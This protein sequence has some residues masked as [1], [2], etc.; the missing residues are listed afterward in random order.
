MISCQT[1]LAG[2]PGRGLVMLCRNGES[3]VMTSYGVSCGGG[4]PM[5][6]GAC[7][8]R[9]ARRSARHPLPFDRV[10]LRLLQAGGV[11]H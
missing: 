2:Q 6:L 8:L 3:I 4:V 11:L 5:G 7:L 1:R 10:V 9:L